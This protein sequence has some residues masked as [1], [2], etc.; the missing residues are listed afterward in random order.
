MMNEIT[1]FCPIHAAPG[2]GAALK[3]A[4]LELA[5]ATRLADNSYLYREGYIINYDNI[6]KTI[7]M[8]YLA[9]N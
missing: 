7:Q 6:H 2:K 4:L 1:L 3:A 9:I 8:S 5:K